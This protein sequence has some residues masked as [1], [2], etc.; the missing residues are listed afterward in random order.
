MHVLCL[1]FIGYYL[2]E[3]NIPTLS[4]KLIEFPFQL[5]TEREFY[6]NFIRNND[7]KTKAIEL[8]LI[9]FYLF[10]FE[11]EFAIIK[12]FVIPYEINEKL[13]IFKRRAYS[14]YLI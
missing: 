7:Y 1:E 2:F 9:S 3:S 10:K 5:N 8:E 13:W 4:S 6:F 11:F 14:G 12:I